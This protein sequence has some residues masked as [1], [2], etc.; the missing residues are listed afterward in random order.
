MVEE[1]VLEVHRME[2]DRHHEEDDIQVQEADRQLI[3]RT[4][5]R[6]Q[7]HPLLFIMKDG[8]DMKE[9][10][11]MIAEVMEEDMKKD[12]EKVIEKIEEVTENI[13]IIET[14]TKMSTVKDI[15]I[16]NDRV[17]RIDGGLT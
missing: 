8:L 13:M 3:P 17:N 6:L 1:D 14:V 16:E 9:E 5:D 11:M 12:M 4:E 7:D 2:D 10:D 15:K